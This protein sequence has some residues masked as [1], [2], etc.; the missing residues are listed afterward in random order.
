LGC[1]WYEIG[2]RPYLIDM[3]PPTEK[4]LSISHFKEG[5]VTN[6]FVRPFLIVKMV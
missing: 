6:Y 2:Q 4:E 3:F 5:F 1:K